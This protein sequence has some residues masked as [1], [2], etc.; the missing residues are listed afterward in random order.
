MANTNSDQIVAIASSSGKAASNELAGRLRVAYFSVGTVPTGASDTMTLTKLPKGAKV[1][2][3]RCAFSTSQG[4]ATTA[5]GISGTS[6]K[7]LAAVV[8]STAGTVIAPTTAENLGTDT[9]A[10]ETI[11][12]TNATAAWTAGAFKGFLFYVVD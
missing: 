5:I 2:G 6:G 9:T 12:A 8:V 10:E 11:I 3:G 4:T 1:L 7:Y